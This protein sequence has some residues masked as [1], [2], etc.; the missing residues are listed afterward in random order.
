MRCWLLASRSAVA[1]ASPARPRRPQPSARKLPRR[2][3]RQ[4]LRPSGHRSRRRWSERG[5]CRS[6]KR[7]MGQRSKS[8]P[9]FQLFRNVG[10]GSDRDDVRDVESGAV[11]IAPLPRRG[12]GYRRVQRGC[13]PAC[14]QP[15]SSGGG[16][17]HFVVSGDTLTLTSVAV[18]ACPFR[19]GVL[20]AH[21]WQRQ[22]VP[23]PTQST[24]PTSS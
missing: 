20:T 5:R 23:K 11:H 17:Y 4:R 10:V 18:D 13:D 14:P 2:L 7:L 3:Q 8:W 24:V 9:W 16:R 15:S 22:H 19:Q 6:T 12:D 21:P 1:R